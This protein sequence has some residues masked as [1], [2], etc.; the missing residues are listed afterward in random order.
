MAAQALLDY[1]KLTDLELAARFAARDA[2]AVRLVTGRNNQRLFRT[3]WSILKNRSEAEDV[4]QET[5]LRALGAIGR[6]EG[7]SSLSTWLTRIAINEALTRKRAQQRRA[8][9]FNDTSVFVMEEY[10]EK[11]MGSAE[12]RLSPESE[13]ARKQ[14][15]GFLET[16]VANLPDN[17]RTVFVL[18]EIEDMSVEEAA[19]VLGVPA[20]T[21]RSRHLRARKKIQEALDPELRT[22]LGET[23]PF[24]GAD[25]EALTASVLNRMGISESNNDGGSA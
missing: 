19:G 4:V 25:C 24:A 10:R 13:L 6:F 23:F 8:N 17:F 16:A 11:I 12:R 20:E 9:A 5:Y 18:R 15:R 14:L 22:A 7:R 3:A 21:V 2:R 1:E